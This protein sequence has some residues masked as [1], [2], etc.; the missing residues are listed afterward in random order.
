[1]INN[2][3]YRSYLCSSAKTDKVGHLFE[4]QAMHNLCVKVHDYMM[5]LDLYLY[6]P[7]VAPLTYPF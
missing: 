3:S 6:I 7:L 5:K 1:M 2:I 4:L